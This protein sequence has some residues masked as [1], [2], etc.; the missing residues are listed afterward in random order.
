MLLY[1]Y[2]DLREFFLQF[3]A[4]SGDS[5]AGACPDHHHVQLLATLPQYLLCRPVIVSQGVPRVA[6]LPPDNSNR[7]SEQ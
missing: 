5:S 6:I 4:N 2:L 1:T 7:V 3:A